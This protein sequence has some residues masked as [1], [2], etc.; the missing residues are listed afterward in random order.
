[1]DGTRA[2]QDSPQAG[3]STQTVDPSVA[4]AEVRSRLEAV[5]Q[6]SSDALF[7]VSLDGVIVAWSPAAERI[8]GY[9]A[10]AIIGKPLSILVPDDRRHELSTTITS[11]GQG[12]TVEDFET[13]RLRS[14]GVPIDVSL[15]IAPTRDERGQITGVLVV[16]QDITA[17]NEALRQAEQSSVKLSDRERMLR[18]ALVALRKSHEEAKS[19]QLQL[20]QAAKLESVGRL[21]AGVAHEVKNPLAVILFAIDY[22]AET[23]QAPDAN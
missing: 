23:I 10:E 19:T 2:G 8:Y 5:W 15:S 14:D 21:A 3:T 16:A 17:I 4:A 13:V 20:V 6:L 18:R 22:L 7:A 1:M 12:A 9:A 11:I